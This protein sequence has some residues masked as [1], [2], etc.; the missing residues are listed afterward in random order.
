MAKTQEGL[1]LKVTDRMNL[2]PPGERSN[3]HYCINSNIG[4]ALPLELELL[5]EADKY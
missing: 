2:L 4:S 5:F 3:L 1:D